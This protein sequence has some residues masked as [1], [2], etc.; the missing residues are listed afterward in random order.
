MSLHVRP[1]T[2]GDIEAVV[3]L[4]KAAGL[5]VPHNDPYEDIRIC[6]ASPNAEILIG[7]DAQELAA[8]IM[9]GHDG[10]CGWYHYMGASPDKQMGELGRQIM[11]VAE[12]WLQERGV[13][14]AQLVLRP[15]NAKVK[16]FYAAAIQRKLHCYGKTVSSCS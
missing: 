12:N 1:I 9:V 10:H 2:G 8:A 13:G 7:F 3:R 6:R 5:I 11:S 14:K 4:W 15:S 16:N